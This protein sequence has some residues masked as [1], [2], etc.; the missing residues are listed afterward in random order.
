MA[1][2]DMIE[3]DVSLPANGVLERT[4]IVLD[5]TN[6]IQVYANAQEFLLSRSVLTATLDYIDN[7]SI[8]GKTN[9]T[10]VNYC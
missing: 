3:Y 7:A 1:D 6:G 8:P 9:G 4:G 2:A 10:Q 5:A